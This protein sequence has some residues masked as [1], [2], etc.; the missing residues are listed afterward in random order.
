MNAPQRKQLFFIVDEFLATFTGQRVIFHE[1]NCFLGAYFLAK[2]TENAPQ[3]INLEFPGRLLHVANLE[4]ADWSWWRDADRFRGT[5][6]FAKLARN[7]LNPII[8]IIN[9]VRRASIT[10]RHD[11]FFLRI[12]HGHFLPEEMAN[13]D[14]KPTNDRG[15]IKLFP[16]I[17]F[18]SLN[19][20]ELIPGKTKAP[21]P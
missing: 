7:A 17:K 19:N 9:E 2:P 12:L 20:H 11:P 1:K 18:F 15:E 21:E 8:L 3:H 6:K 4:S 13:R 5:N 14:F 10:F 16:E